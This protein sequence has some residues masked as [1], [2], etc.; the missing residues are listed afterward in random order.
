MRGKK[1]FNL[2]FYQEIYLNVCH[3]ALINKRAVNQ[4]KLIK[5]AGLKKYHSI[6]VN[7]FNI[8]LFVT[9]PFVIVEGNFFLIS[10]ERKKFIKW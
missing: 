5:T 10:K 6:H 1:D 3:L 8:Y 9:I 2:N 7:F 4:L